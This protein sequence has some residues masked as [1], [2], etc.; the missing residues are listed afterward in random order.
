[1]I[2]KLRKHSCILVTGGAGFIGSHLVEALLKKGY[3]VKALDDFSTGRR[4]NLPSSNDCLEIIEGKIENKILVDQ[5][6][7]GVDAVVHLAAIA[8]V[9]TSVKDPLGTHASNF[10]GTLNL[11]ESCR[12]NNVKRFLFASS[13]AVYGETKTM[14]ISE[15]DPP[16]PL[17]PYASDK[18]ACEQYIDF[19]RREH[20]LNPGV[21]RFFNI[22]GSRQ[23]P[24]SPYSG[25]ISI[26][27]DRALAEQTITVY[28][29]GL[30]TRDFMFVED[31]IVLLC[32]A[33]ENNNTLRIGPVNFGTGKQTSLKEVI[34]ILENLT[35]KK[36]RVIYADARPG[37]IRDSLADVS[38]LNKTFSFRSKTRLIDGMNKLFNSL[39]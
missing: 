28:G 23:D 12:R 8:S 15:K 2:D 35:G 5:A 1:M 32:D 37:D 38:L 31:L 16:N 29:D 13:A 7:Q 26:F 33:V 39:E 34:A 14:P 17:T 10:I 9:Q 25:V 4:T 11:L 19:Y 20:G 24:S 3:S 21:F 27:I 22:Y 6:M 36:M 18:L 30:Q